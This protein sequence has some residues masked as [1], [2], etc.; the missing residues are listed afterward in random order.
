MSRTVQEAQAHAVSMIPEQR[1]T[2]A[3]AAPG[4]GRVWLW[5]SVIIV[6]FTLRP[7]GARGQSMTLA[8][9]L[10]LRGGLQV[11]PE[12]ASVTGLSSLFLNLR[13]VF[14]D[15]EGDRFILVGQVDVEEE[16]R[17]THL[18]QAYAQYKGHLG[19]WNLRIGRYL[20]P[21]GLH[22]YYDT[23]RL[24]LAAH[25]AEALGIK[26]DEGIQVHGYFGSVDYAVSVGRGFHNRATPMGRIGWQGANFRLGLSYLYGWLPSFA[27]QESVVVGELLPGARLIRKH[28]VALDYEHV[29]GPVTL[30]AEPLSG[31]DEGR[32]VFGG[33]GEVSYALS[34]RWELSANGAFLRSQLV[35][36]RRRAG[37]AVSFR[38]GPGIFL[39]GGYG[40]RRDFGR[41][42][43][44][45]VVQ[46]YG[47]FSRALKE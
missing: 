38:V 39:R 11:H 45:F 41:T 27:D 14:A 34:P 7:T 10:D 18:Y 9:G 29:L 35:G 36:T 23:E 4:A 26:L 46:L 32:L 42:T 5:V 44:V 24:L 25:E 31:A 22:A 17:R 43:D 30:R 40:H 1:S 3:G 15:E 33:Y 6:V 37:G 21:F 16:L 28:R 47:E 2:A 12:V 8:G 13:K 19:K 20:V